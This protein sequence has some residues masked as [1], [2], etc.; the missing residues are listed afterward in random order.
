LVSLDDF[1]RLVAGIYGAALTPQTWLS[2]MDDISAALGAHTA[3]IVVGGTTSRTPKVANIS[4]E[5]GLAYVEHY[6]RLDYILE[7]VERGPVGQLSPTAPL[8]ALNPMSEFDA[9]W[10]RPNHMDDGLFVRLTHGT[11]TATFLVADSAS[12]EGFA[13]PERIR[14]VNALVPHLQQALR[15]EGVLRDAAADT[16]DVATAVDSVRHG[17]VVVTADSEVVH[18]NSVAADI[19]G[20][21]DGLCLRK[22]RMETGR[23]S[24]GARL[25]RSVGAAAAGRSGVRGGDSMLCARPSGLRPY[26]LHVVPTESAD[27]QHSR[28]LVLIVDPEKRPEPPREVLHRL[29]GLTAAETEV[30]VR[31]LQGEGVKPIAEQLGVS[32]AT[33]KTHLQKVFDKTDTHRQ[34]QLVRLLLAIT[35]Q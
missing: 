9:D 18:M 22:G 6:S 35:P 12:I 16:R 34:A 17:V 10:M 23:A 21:A 25:A 8:R 30:A 32:Q 19:F 14:V 24:T 1:S 13:T 28:A 27:P 4:E 5:A 2:A 29:Y 26:I 33:V 11:A 15:T 31:V 3:S 20:A 7:A